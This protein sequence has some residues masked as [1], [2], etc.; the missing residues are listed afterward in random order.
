MPAATDQC[1]DGPVGAGSADLTPEQRV[2]LCAPTGM[3]GPHLGLDNCTM[4]TPLVR[5]ESERWF[6]L[7]W[8]S[9]GCQNPH[10]PLGRAPFRIGGGG[11]RT[12]FTPGGSTGNQFFCLD[13]MKFR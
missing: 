11:L 9:R 10:P 6:S 3:V 8:S 12:F 1:V 2:E 7:W 13:Q 5:A 4:K